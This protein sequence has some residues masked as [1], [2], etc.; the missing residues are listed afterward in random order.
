MADSSKPAQPPAA[1]PVLQPQG[2]HAGKSSLPLGHHPFTLVGSRNRAHLHL[3]SNTISR[4]HACIIS[5]KGG[6]YI[7]DL[8]SRTGVLINGQ[9]VREGDLHDGDL[10]Q[11]GAFEFRF[12][13]PS[14]IELPTV[15]QPEMATLEMD[16]RALTPI[17]GRTVLIGRRPNCDIPLE[18]NAVSSTHAIIFEVDGR[19]YIRD[20]GSRSGT[21]VNGESV[22][23]KALEFGDQ[24]IV[25]TTH[26][27]YL[28][29]SATTEAAEEDKA[30]P[31]SLESPQEPV[32]LQG[33]AAGAIDQED[34]EPIG[35]SFDEPAAHEPEP[36]RIEPAAAIPLE[37]L[38]PAV[39]HAAAEIET[40]PAEAE[41][42]HEV[43]GLKFEPVEEHLA[44]APS[45]AAEEDL[46]LDFWTPEA[47][48]KG[49]TADET[50]V[51]ES[52]P[53]ELELPPPVAHE[54]AAVEEHAQEPP[55]SETSAIAEAEP[56]DVSEPAEIPAKEQVAS[57]IDAPADVAPSQAELERPE[58]QAPISD[59][60]EP[61]HEAATAV[62]PEIEPVSETA[63]TEVH[64]AQPS[65]EIEVSQTTV[66]ES[67]PVEPLAAE[68][69]AEIPVAHEESPPL[70]VEKPEPVAEQPAESA[71]P[72]E[73]EPQAPIE[74]GGPFA[75]EET[76]P[77]ERPQ[78][79][80]LSAVKFEPQ[81][82]EP[83]ADESSAQEATM[84][85][86][87]TLAAAPLL[88]LGVPP[89]PQEPVIPEAIAP[90][91]EDT[92]AG[93]VEPEAAPGKGKRK[94]R[95]P[96]KKKDSVEA[97]AAQET[98]STQPAAEG[99]A[100][101]AELPQAQPPKAEEPSSLTVAADIVEIA[102]AVV[103]AA[104]PHAQIVEL[105]QTDSAEESGV[106]SSKQASAPAIEETPASS[107]ASEERSLPVQDVDVEVAPNAVILESEPIE[108]TETISSTSENA[109][110]AGSWPHDPVTEAALDAVSQVEAVETI[111]STEPTVESALSI[112]PAFESAEPAAGPGE[113]VDS[114]SSL[115]DTAFGRA[116]QE[117]AGSGLGPLVE[118]PSPAP[119]ETTRA[120]FI[121]PPLAEP[122]DLA[123]DGGDGLALEEM[124]SPPAPFNLASESQ[125]SFDLPETSNESSSSITQDIELEPPLE[126][127]AT[128][129]AES[130]ELTTSEPVVGQAIEPPATEAPIDFSAAPA[131]P[132][133]EHAGP[134]KERQEEATPTPTLPR[135]TGGGELDTGS[136]E[137]AMP[138]PAAKPMSAIDPF[139]GM[140]R[141]MGSFIGGMPL[142]LGTAPAAPVATSVIG[143][144]VPSPQVVARLN[145]PRPQA[146][147]APTPVNPVA[148][149]AGTAP[150]VEHEPPAAQAQAVQSSAVE[151]ANVSL[152]EAP[153][154][155]ESHTSAEDHPLTFDHGPSTQVPDL[156]DALFEGEEPLE[157]FDETADQLDGLPE[158]LEPI[159]DVHGALAEQQTSV[160]PTVAAN[161]RVEAPA[162]TTSSPAP[163]APPLRSLTAD[164]A[165]IKPAVDAKPATTTVSVPPFAGSGLSARAGMNGFAGIPIPKLKNADVFSQTVFPPLDDSVFRP[166][167][168]DI[169]PMKVRLPGASAGPDPN[170]KDK[171]QIESKPGPWRVKG[172]VPGAV[173]ITQRE[174]SN[175][176][177]PRKPWW[178][179]IRHLLPIL[180]LLMVGS[181]AAIIRFIPPRT[182]VR[183]ALR[184]Q[185]ADGK[186]AYVLARKA[187]V[188]DLREKLQHPD[189]RDIV[190]ANLKEQGISPGFVGDVAAMQQ[191]SS[192]D[193]S[194]FD[195]K[196][197]ALLLTRVSNDPKGDEQRMATIL[198][199]MYSMNRTAAEQAPAVEKRAQDAHSQ[200]D[201]IKK[202]VDDQQATVSKLSDQIKVVAGSSSSAVLLDPEE[203]AKKLQ[204]LDADLH[205]ALAQ[206]NADVSARRQALMDAQGAATDTSDPA[207]TQLRQNLASMQQRLA[208][209]KSALS[210]PA[211]LNATIDD[212]LK[213]LAQT[214]QPIILTAK[215][216]PLLSFANEGNA[217]IGEIRKALETARQDDA[218]LA[219]LR[220]QIANHQEARSRQLWLLDETLKQLLEQRSAQAQ[221]YTAALASG[222]TEEATKTR[223]VLDDLDSRIDARRQSLAGSGQ[224]PDDLEKNLDQSIDQIAQERH[225]A[226]RKINEALGEL[227]NPPTGNQIPPDEQMILQ[228]IAKDV[229]DLSTAFGQYETATAPDSSSEAMKQ[230]RTLELQIAQQQTQLDAYQPPNPAAGLP[231]ARNALDAAQ[232]AEARAQVD[233]AGNLNLLSSALALK[234]AEAGLPDLVKRMGDARLAYESAEEDLRKIPVVLSPDASAVQ[235]THEADQRVWYL[236]YALGGLLLLFIVP[237]WLALRHPPLEMPYAAILTE[238]YDVPSPRNGKEGPKSAADLEND[239]HPAMA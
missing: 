217:A 62:E 168:I 226:S 172:A 179:S 4:N 80:D 223:G 218:T 23:Q 53:E 164:P 63:P 198:S 195:E 178:R 34:H 6:M 130:L 149:P 209:A 65:G 112:E 108:A 93:T 35:L 11:I 225:Q 143:G 210:D 106:D 150:S 236:S 38:Q 231:A 234:D 205:D 222:A 111:E 36:E 126:L 97:V 232:L 114:D 137:S 103:D 2:S 28:A 118:E 190:A 151:Q 20:L 188:M 158:S 212:D 78:E 26:F 98:E 165:A 235:T 174:P 206:A 3:L 58:D 175:V 100:A 51:V 83:S 69:P 140:V 122:S 113:I 9:K 213:N 31:I 146:T 24:I 156:D 163:A 219:F 71:T 43:E 133:D 192:P 59:S 48:G 159:A 82:A 44:A 107:Q 180:L 64:V 200:V 85:E 132:Q 19:R 202:Q 233:Y 46:G 73:A 89:I 105:P 95:K 32:E 90:A 66:S 215:G 197:Q 214:L 47:E 207:L 57:A 61:A 110:A 39:E 139:R 56:F 147:A 55:A 229:V 184:L 224:Y 128:P 136:P 144:A 70:E 88:D 18:S 138:A 68:T 204:K 162:T 96:R 50:V 189:L 45:A 40:H 154:A 228:P 84:S 91:I 49:L 238:R 67:A 81:T 161:F 94:G 86:Q 134:D 152:H 176:P 166:Q 121:T 5:T 191:I 14:N 155:V 141:D 181:A 127:D 8:G 7:R 201:A 54:P 193:I 216:G 119:A 237:I 25:G 227:K 129:V 120:E 17:D 37:E 148:P 230:A 211:P 124:P 170:K 22:H 104:V 196:E 145:P 33:V 29:A 221:R 123:I 135:S 99:T 160:A 177:P 12:V 109:D 185:S 182:L 125:I 153:P 171:K 76:P 27:R 77:K 15:R 157:L 92:L 79:V 116:V 74:L 13:D 87:A 173:P 60:V 142:S 42:Q 102:P 208:A 239:E 167:P 10:L 187:Q 117:M 52:V 199:V 72:G 41:L 1:G 16:G 21:Q 30:A 203:A 75:V 194:P 169:P 186:E 183:G 101:E 220:Q 131:P 115:S